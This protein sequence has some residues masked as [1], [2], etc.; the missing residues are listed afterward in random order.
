MWT[1]RCIR[2]G[3]SKEFFFLMRFFSSSLYLLLFVLFERNVCSWIICIW[4]QI[5][6]PVFLYVF[7]QRINKTIAVIGTQALTYCQRTTATG[8]RS[9]TNG[10]RWAGTRRCKWYW[11]V[12]NWST[13][14]LASGNTTENSF[15]LL[16]QRGCIG[17]VRSHSNVRQRWRRRTHGAL[18]KLDRCRNCARIVLLYFLA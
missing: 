9:D 1:F 13:R 10:C 15:F 3:R 4:K 7:L 16:T 5:I 6:R 17:D 2:H 18:I 14:M 8:M 12:S 11:W